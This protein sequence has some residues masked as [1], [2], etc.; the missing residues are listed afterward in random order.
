MDIIV[1]IVQVP[2]PEHFSEVRFDPVRGTM[3]REGIPAV[4]NP[5]DRNALEAALQ[6][7]EKHRGTITVTSMGPPQF[8]SS[9]EEALAMGA[10]RAIH[11]CDR[12]LGGADTLATALALAAGV[13]K[14]GRFDLILCGA[15]SMAGATGQVGP[16]LAELLDIPQ[17]TLVKAIESSD[18]GKLV[19]RRSLE[20]GYMRVQ[21]SLPALLTVTRGLNTPSL[22]TIMGI[23]EASSKEILTWGCSEL[24]LSADMVGQAGSPTRVSSISQRQAKSK[25]EVFSGPAPEA[26]KKAVARL[27]ELIEL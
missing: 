25:G 7:R 16:Q 9:L 5:P 11:L 17:V 26:V 3:I 21:V 15:E 1:C 2:D 13:R 18:E 4:I 23:M 27:R 19:V 8:R 10:D 14:L 24:G 12:A 6:L 22:P 20:H